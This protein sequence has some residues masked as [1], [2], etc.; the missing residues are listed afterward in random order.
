VDDRLTAGSVSRAARSEELKSPTW[1]NA[2]WLVIWLLAGVIP[3]IPFAWDTSVWI[4]VTLR[5]PENE[6]NWW[7]LFRGAPFFLAYPMIWLRLRMLFSRQPSTP[8]ERRLIWSAVGCSV[9][10]TILV[11]VPFLLRFAGETRWQRLALP[12]LI[13][14]IAALSAIGALLLRRQ[15]SPT[16]ACIVGLDTA[17]LGNSLL[18]LIMYMRPSGIHW[19]R[20]GWIVSAV[21]FWP[22]LFEL[23]WLLIQTFRAE[24]RKSDLEPAEELTAARS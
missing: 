14:G 3:F 11:H 22:I 19:W 23:I 8:M 5:L 1:V 12:S 4:A 24:G 10:C 13:F 20:A 6:G 15:I 21:I 2:F 18:S 9:G 7:H 16:R 17:Y